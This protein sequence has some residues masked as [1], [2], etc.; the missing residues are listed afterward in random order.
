MFHPRLWVEYEGKGSHCEA[1]NFK[2]SISKRYPCWLVVKC[3]LKLKVLRLVSKGD[4]YKSQLSRRA[5]KPPV[6]EGI[7]RHNHRFS[8]ARLHVSCAPAATEVEKEQAGPLWGE[9]SSDD[10]QSLRALSEESPHN[11]VSP[12][13]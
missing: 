1:C 5:A 9:M 4:C 7:F 6:F 3:G 2:G 11:V 8:M 10:L 13:S 12:A